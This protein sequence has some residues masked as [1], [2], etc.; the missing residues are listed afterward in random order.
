MP[1]PIKPISDQE[2]DKYS[3]ISF[4]VDYSMLVNRVPEIKAISDK[5]IVTASDGDAKILMEIWT[6]AEKEN[7][8]Y[9]ISSDVK[10]SYRDIMR[11]KTNGLLT[12]T[13]EKVQLTDRAKSVIR[14]M[15]LGENNKFLKVKKDKSYTEIMA[16]MDKRGKKGYRIV[17]SGTPK[18]A[19]NILI[20]TTKQS[21]SE[22]DNLSLISCMGLRDGG[23]M[24]I[25]FSDG[26]T[27]MYDHG[28][29]SS[30]KGKFVKGFQDRTIVDLPEK[31][32]EILRK[33]DRFGYKDTI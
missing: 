19:S 30:T 33:D 20:R 27:C 5:R 3:G 17:G 15:V 11:L 10:V 12:G 7:D 8:F 2:N 4:Q 14:M 1:I 9:K 24:R 22:I 32:K 28:I 29:N 16:S 23:S 26:F 13:N 6:N 25:E 31:Y 21:S 18:F